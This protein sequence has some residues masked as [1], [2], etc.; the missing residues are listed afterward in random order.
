M[1]TYPL[2]YIFPEHTQLAIQIQTPSCRHISSGSSQIY[3]SIRSLN[4]CSNQATT[5]HPIEL[6]ILSFSLLLPTTATPIQRRNL[7]HLKT[8]CKT[9]TQ[10]TM[11]DTNSAITALLS[12]ANINTTPQTLLGN[13][14]WS[15]VSDSVWAYIANDSPCPQ[16]LL[17]V[18]DVRMLFDNLKLDCGDMGGVAYWVHGDESEG[19]AERIE[20]GLVE[21]MAG[22]KRRWERKQGLLTGEEDECDR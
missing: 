5:M 6:L 8:S 12:S 18:W 19:R 17:S 14:H 4:H 1:G 20:V 13:R 11:D 15:G 16:T 2:L 10:S 22:E 7:T 3:N 9:T 21:M